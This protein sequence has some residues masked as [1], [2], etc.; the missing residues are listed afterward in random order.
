[1]ATDFEVALAEFDDGPPRRVV[2]LGRTG[3]PRLVAVVRGFFA[4]RP[5]AVPSRPTAPR[6]APFGDRGQGRGDPT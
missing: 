3:D 2:L 1:M 6:V 5:A 4:G